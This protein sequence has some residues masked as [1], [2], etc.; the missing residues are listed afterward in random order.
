MDRA[1]DWADA[2]AAAAR[3]APREVALALLT[4]LL[5]AIV[6]RKATASGSGGD[7]VAGKRPPMRSLSRADVSAHASADDAWIV[8]GNGVYDI[9]PYVQ[10]HPGGTAAILRNAGGDATAGFHGP[11]HPARVFDMIDDFKIGDLVDP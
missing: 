9:S 5:T 4:L 11:Q 7:V 2:A 3:E 10:E 8:I 1:A 6:L